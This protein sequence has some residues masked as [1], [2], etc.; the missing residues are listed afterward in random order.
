VLGEK[1]RDLGTDKTTSQSFFF[2]IILWLGKIDG[3]IKCKFEEHARTSLIVW[4]QQT[5]N[6]REQSAPSG[7]ITD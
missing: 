1:S 2:R 7:G 3:S 6:P 4:P 5:C